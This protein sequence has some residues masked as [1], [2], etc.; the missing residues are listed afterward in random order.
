M[1]TWARSRS[2]FGETVIEQDT[3]PADITPI[4]YWDR[5]SREIGAA[6]QSPDD[7]PIVVVLDDLDR[8]GD[9]EAQAR[10]LTLL[11]SDERLHLVVTT[12]STAIFDDATMLDVDGLTISPRIC[13][14][15]PPNRRPSCRPAESTSRH[16]FWKPCRP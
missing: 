14:S 11:E 12:R 6:A 5:V 1:R 7:S 16:T 2:D 3:P 15:L 4:G 10:A 13:C 9:P 8:L